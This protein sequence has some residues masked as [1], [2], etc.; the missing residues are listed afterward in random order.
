MMSGD[1]ND[2]IYIILWPT[3][4][5]DLCIT[6][7]IDIYINRYISGIGKLFRLSTRSW[8][9]WSLIDPHI[10]NKPITIWHN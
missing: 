1:L 7:E 4:S 2:I 9:P 10:K 3:K 5:G 6:I 8:N